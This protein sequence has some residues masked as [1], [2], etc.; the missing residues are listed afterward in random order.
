[1]KENIF[2]SKILLFGEYSILVNSKGLSIPFP[3]FKGSL[4]IPLKKTGISKKSNSTL[5]DFFKY[6]K[7][8]VEMDFHSFK[9]DL[10]NGIYFDSSIPVGYG[11]GSSGAIVAA[12]YEKYAQNKIVL[13][14]EI[15]NEKLIN[16]KEIFS[17]MESFFH[18]K[19]SG[20]DPLNIYLGKPIL[21]NSINEI[22]V[23][24]IP[25]GKKNKIVAVFLLDSGQSSSTATM[26]KIFKTKMKDEAFKKM[27]SKEFIKYTNECIDNFLI[28]DT[29]NLF[30]N[31]KELSKIVLKNFK[32][33]I[34]HSIQ[35]LW[36]QGI[37]RDSYFLKLCGSG[38]GGYIL[39]FTSNF[40]K[41]KQ[42]LSPY[43]LTPVYFM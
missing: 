1:M 13:S 32:P 38:G 29:N 15:S 2:N 43:N 4:K 31:I 41:A 26:I 22:E 10:E 11:V 7:S 34:P 5:L 3:L 42:E 8:I 16:L 18:G 35:A 14:K 40:E 36:E 27:L 25:D 12:V 28:A 21:I 37:S 9:I 39:G 23:T 17:K 20:L 33:M 24:K 30:E 6:L 19:S